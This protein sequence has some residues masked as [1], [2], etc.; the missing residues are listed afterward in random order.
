[1]VSPSQVIY[2]QKQPVISAK[3]DSNYM[4]N[5]A[6]PNFL[7]YVTHIQRGHGHEGESEYLWQ[8]TPAL[9]KGSRRPTSS[10]RECCAP[11]A[12][13]AARPSRILL[14]SPPLYSNLIHTAKGGILE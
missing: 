5:Y 9:Y 3:E 8:R 2:I 14:P 1:M 11:D 6:A 4:A 10:Y 13:S 12:S 7:A